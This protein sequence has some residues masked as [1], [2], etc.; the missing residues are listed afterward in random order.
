[1][2]G[3]GWLGRLHRRS[4][5]LADFY[6]A[7]R[8]MGFGVLFLTL[9]ATQYSGNTMFGYTGESYRIGFEWTVSVLFMFSIIAGYLLF[10]PRLVVIARKFQFITPGDYIRERF[11]SR[12]LTLLATILM[13][14]ALGNYTLA[15]LK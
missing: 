15:Q 1:M 7:G 9:Y 2:I 4:D 6:L 12:R 11:G 14:Y 10:A 5:S 8:S 3:I 13:I